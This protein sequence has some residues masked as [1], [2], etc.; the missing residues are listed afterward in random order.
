MSSKA[1]V[2]TF[3][4][5]LFLAV[6]S[7][8]W[9]KTI[10]TKFQVKG[11]TAMAVF[12]ATDPDDP[13]IE[14]FATVVASNLMEKQKPGG[15]TETVRTLLV[16]GRTDTCLGINLFSGDGETTD[17]SFQFSLSSARL[18]TTMFVFDSVSLQDYEFEVD[19]TWTAEGPAVFH[20]CKE[21]FRDKELGLKILTQLR[22]RHAPAEAVGTVVGVGENFTPEPSDE[23]ELQT[24]NDGT[25]II[26]KTQ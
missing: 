22:G 23:A 21:T 11:D 10:K 14:N 4:A 8:A 18:T 25:I 1:F 9:A 2:G 12:Q 20:R 13:C 3:T 17:Q 19:M 6:G 24:R 15:K 5:V 16:V 26:E 7:T